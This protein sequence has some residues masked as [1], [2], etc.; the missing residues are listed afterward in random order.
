MVTSPYRQ[1]FSTMASSFNHNL[2]V[3]LEK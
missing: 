3:D 1:E 2:V